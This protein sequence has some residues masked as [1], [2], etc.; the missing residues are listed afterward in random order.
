MNDETG[1]VDIVAEAVR[2]ARKGLGLSQE[3]LALE[4]GLDRTYVSQVERGTRN[5]TIIVLARLAKALKTTPDKLLVPQRK[6][7]A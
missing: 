3:D 5:C 6:G 1:I 4:A 7:R 2:K